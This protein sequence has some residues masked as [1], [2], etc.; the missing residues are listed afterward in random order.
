M[1]HSQTWRDAGVVAEAYRF[2]FP[3]R[4]L[5]T[6]PAEA[7]ATIDD[8]NLV[9]DSIKRAED[10]DAVVLRIYEAHG[11][12]GSAQ[13]NLAAR[14]KSATFCNILEDP[15]APA[16]PITPG[17]PIQIPYQP[18]KIITLKLDPKE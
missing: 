4:S 7:F 9:I 5:T 3:L 13:L 12:R 2:N 11:A 1:P 14:F 6:A 10:S 15:I 18:H 8:P 16:E 17:Q